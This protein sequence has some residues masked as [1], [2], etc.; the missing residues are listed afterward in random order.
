M[1][2]TGLHH[3]IVRTGQRRLVADVP[4]FSVAASADQALDKSFVKVQPDIFN[5][6][7]LQK[8]FVE[9]RRSAT[10]VEDARPGR[11]QVCND[12]VPGEVVTAV[13][14]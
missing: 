4:D 14:N 6:F 11:N 1:I 7:A 9:D 3:D 5:R 2:K 13:Q 8:P 12:F 10:Y